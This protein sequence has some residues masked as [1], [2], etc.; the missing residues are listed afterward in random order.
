MPALVDTTIR[1]LSQEPLAARVQT[2]RVLELAEILDQAGFAY[3]EVSGGGCF[4]S[5][6]RRGVESPWERI[7][8]IRSRTT[9]PRGIARPRSRP[10]A[11]RANRP[12]ERAPRRP[13][14]PGRRRRRP[15]GRGRGG[16]GGSGVDRLRALPG[17]AL[18]PPSVGR[19]ADAFTRRPLARHGSGR[20]HAL[21]RIRARRRGARRRTGSAALPARGGAGG[22]APPAGGAPGGGG[23]QP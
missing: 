17:R 22:R 8:A 3:L 13:P 12:G 9:T 1:L 18:A 14:L 2:A 20:R 7:R 21:A 23:A 16:A 4:D 11:R 10:E 19:V 5:A 6:V 15:R